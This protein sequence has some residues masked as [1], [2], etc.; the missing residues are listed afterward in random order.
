MKR[1]LLV[2]TTILAIVM[3]ATPALAFSIPG[4]DY[5]KSMAGTGLA[6]TIAVGVGVLITVF[7]L[8]RYTHIITI[9]S[10]FAQSLCVALGVTFEASGTVFGWIAAVFAD[11][12]LTA[13]EVKQAPGVW[14]QF[15]KSARESANTVKVAW[16]SMKA[17][18]KDRPNA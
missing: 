2:L 7:G 13:D 3:A 16:K 5:V 8:A 14:K 17:Q 6:Q 12:K 10:I 15:W 1:F 9:I 18:L 4:W 11:M